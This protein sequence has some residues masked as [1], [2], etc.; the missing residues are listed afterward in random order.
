M[1]DY[2]VIGGWNGSRKVPV[3]VIA[4]TASGFHVTAME[5]VFLPGR[6][7][8]REGQSTFVPRDAV[9]LEDRGNQQAE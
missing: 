3:N 5:Q 8:L 6:G 9:I 1:S 2:L 4:E 7:V